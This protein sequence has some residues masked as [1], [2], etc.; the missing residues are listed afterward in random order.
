MWAYRGSGYTTWHMPVLVES[1]LYMYLAPCSPLFL[2]RGPKKRPS[3]HMH[4]AGPSQD[5]PSVASISVPDPL[6]R[7]SPSMVP[8][9]LIDGRF[10]RF[11]FILAA[12]RVVLH[13]LF[14]VWKHSRACPLS[15][16]G[17]C[18]H[19]SMSANGL[20]P[21]TI[22]QRRPE[23][24]GFELLNQQRIRIGAVCRHKRIE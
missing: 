8:R 4:P 2:Q 11:I 24:T 15:T 18:S 10:S 14:R 17:P 20:P 23:L 22:R 3:V 12:V 13:L 1:L 7:S 9:E 21:V 16:Y 6:I 19:D 5:P